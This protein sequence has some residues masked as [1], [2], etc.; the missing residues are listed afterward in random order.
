MK[1]DTVKKIRAD[2]TSVDYTEQKETHEPCLV[3]H[4]DKES[5]VIRVTAEELV[6]LKNLSE[7]ISSNIYNPTARDIV[8]EKTNAFDA[9]LNN[10]IGKELTLSKYDPDYLKGEL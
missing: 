3:F 6:A 5:L 8:K 10:V 1:R 9:I 2:V 7:Y 4:Y